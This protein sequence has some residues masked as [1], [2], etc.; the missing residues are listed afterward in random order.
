MNQPALVVLVRHMESVG[1]TI[2]SGDERATH[3]LPIHAFPITERGKTQGAAVH[4]V[5]SS[6]YG[7]FDHHF[8][9][10]YLRTRQSLALVAPDVDPTED[11]RLDEWDKG[12]WYQMTEAEVLRRYSNED[13]VQDKTGTYHY[14][15]PGGETGTDVECRIRSFLNHL[16]LNCSGEK[17]LIS[18]HGRWLFFLQKILLNHQGTTVTMDTYLENGSITV[19]LGKGRTLT[20]EQF[21]IPY[22]NFGNTSI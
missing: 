20:L 19:L 18:C 9:S 14:H 6:Y 1:N 15:A 8:C 3:E 5:V 2:K 13:R 10:T 22:N 4:K 16:Q 11:A 7:K 21:A 12:V 17:V